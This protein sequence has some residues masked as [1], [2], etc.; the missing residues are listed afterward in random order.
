MSLFDEN[1]KKICVLNNKINQ[2]NNELELSHNTNVINANSI[3]QGIQSNKTNISFID[4]TNI[5]SYNKSESDNLFATKTE[6][7]NSIFLENVYHKTEIN[8]NLFFDTQENKI[9]IKKS[10]IPENDSDIN[11][12]SVDKK[13]KELYLSG[14]TLHLGDQQI[15]STSDGIEINK[16]ILRNN[17]N[18]NKIEFHNENNEIVITNNNNDN[19]TT[20]KNEIE[21]TLNNIVNIQQQILQIKNQLNL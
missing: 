16:L 9:E 13:F 1:E 15:K 20:L 12:G 5:N 19:Y 21:D 7:I 14:N 11:L 18:N 10:L 8:D 17:N 2:I 4:I 6:L 3:E